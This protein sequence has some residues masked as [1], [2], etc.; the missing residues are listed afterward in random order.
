MEQTENWETRFN[1]EFL[2]K[3]GD[4]C[5]EWSDIK[6]FIRTELESAHRE[7]YELGL[8]VARVLKNK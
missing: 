5:G 8:K 1:K 3:C 2:Y 4:D 7:G 6:H